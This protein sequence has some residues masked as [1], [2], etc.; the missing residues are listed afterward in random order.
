M[1]DILQVSAAFWHRETSLR[2]IITHA[3]VVLDLILAN[4]NTST[5]AAVGVGVVLVVKVRCKR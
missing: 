3:A 2:K 1:H 4:T 5:T